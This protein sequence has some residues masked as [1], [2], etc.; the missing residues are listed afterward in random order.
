MS[1]CN[2]VDKQFVR[3]PA[4]GTESRSVRGK[5]RRYCRAHAG[6]D[7]QRDGAAIIDEW[8]KRGCVGALS[9][10]EFEIVAR[11]IGDADVAPFDAAEIVARRRERDRRLVVAEYQAALAGLVAAGVET[12]KAHIDALMHLYRLG[13]NRRYSLPPETPADRRAGS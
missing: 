2:W 12:E 8:V 4:E 9:R 6:S 13:L 1:R 10:E 7:N 5:G 11:R 3:C